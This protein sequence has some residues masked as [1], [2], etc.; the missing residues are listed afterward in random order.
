MVGKPDRLHE[1]D[2]IRDLAARLLTAVESLADTG[3]D[4]GQ[5]R[6]AQAPSSG[7]VFLFSSLREG[8]G[9]STIA[10]ALARALAESGRRTVLAVVGKPTGE[11]GVQG[12]VALKDVV[13][14]PQSIRFGQPPLLTVEV[15]PRF[16]DL[17]ESAHN[18]RAWLDAF[19]VM[20]IDAPGLTD[21]LTRYWVPKVQGVV[22][23]LDGEEIA[24]RAVVQ[25]RED[26]ERMGGRLLGVV[27]NRYRSR[28]PRFLEPYFVYG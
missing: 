16:T 4:P 28:I 3:G 24:V 11:P 27:L 12:A 19:H 20:I 13:D 18:P 9:T 21:S 1:L 6:E 17:P 26:L 22:L 14:S 10:A 25:A 15:P 23:I 8:Q 7:V 5:R 2:A